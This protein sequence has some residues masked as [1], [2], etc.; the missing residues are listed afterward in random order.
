MEFLIKTKRLL[1]KKFNVASNSDCLY[2]YQ[3]RRLSRKSFKSSFSLYLFIFF[4]LFLFK[5]HSFTVSA[6]SAT[7]KLSSSSS[8]SNN[9]NKLM[10]SII[11]SSTSVTSSSLRPKDQVSSVVVTSTKSD[12]NSM[13]SINNNHNNNNKNEDKLFEFPINELATLKQSPFYRTY[14]TSSDSG[15]YYIVGVLFMISIIGLLLYVNL[16][17]EYCFRDTCFQMA[18]WRGC[19]FLKLFIITS[20]VSRRSA[21]NRGGGNN[22]SNINNG[23]NNN[24]NNNDANNAIRISGGDLSDIKLLNEKNS[25][26]NSNIY[27]KKNVL[28]TSEYIKMMKANNKLKSMSKS[29]IV[30]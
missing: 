29:S 21:T 6:A 12:L 18:Q 4:L 22:V 16:Y 9:N 19:C 13:I 15:N 25:I 23:I 14:A 26:N 24:H 10:Y 20:Y 7:T 30:V 8:S 3:S 27:T 17:Y 11:G 1:T 2:C 5:A 28:N